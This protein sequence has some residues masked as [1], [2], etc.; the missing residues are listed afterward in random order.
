MPVTATEV[1]PS[2]APE[3]EGKSVQSESMPITTTEVRPSEA[4]EQ[5]G[6]SVQS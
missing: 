5:E 3:Q 4:P 6:K 2:E 1:R